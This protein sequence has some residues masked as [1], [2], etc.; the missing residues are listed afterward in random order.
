MG[1]ALLHLIQKGGELAG[2]SNEEVYWLVTMLTIAAKAN[3][4]HP[5]S[6]IRQRNDVHDM[7]PTHH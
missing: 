4:G 1:S 2:V 5:A 6:I 3:I 7:D